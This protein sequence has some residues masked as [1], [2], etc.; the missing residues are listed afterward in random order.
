MLFSIVLGILIFAYATWMV[1]SFIKKS[2]QGRC[3]ACALK[4]SCDS[5]CSAVSFEERQHIL[6]STTHHTK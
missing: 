6:S 4:D 5:G 3:A 2:R 1:I